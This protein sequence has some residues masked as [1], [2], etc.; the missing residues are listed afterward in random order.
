MAA[1]SKRRNP[2]KKP[3]ANK[4]IA[5]QPASADKPLSPIGKQVRDTTLERWSDLSYGGTFPLDGPDAAYLLRVSSNQYTCCY[6]V[7]EAEM[8]DDERALV[9]RAGK[10]TLPWGGELTDA[11]L[12]G[13][14]LAARLADDGSELDELVAALDGAPDDLA[15]VTG[16][17]RKHVAV[18]IDDELSKLD[19]DDMTKFHARPTLGAVIVDA[20]VGDHE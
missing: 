14:Q 1:A 10:V 11:Q 18:M 20:G 5:K 3:P 8:M 12:A 7:P 13:L 2:A 16:K 17:W 15:A 19:H 4:P 9:Q 6:V